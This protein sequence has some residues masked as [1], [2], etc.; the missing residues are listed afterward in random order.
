MSYT[1][2]GI[3]SVA[4]SSVSS[5]VINLDAI[6]T[7]TTTS[8]GNHTVKVW[9]SADGVP[10]T[11]TLSGTFDSVNKKFTLKSGTTLPSSVTAASTAVGILK[12][13]DNNWL[14]VAII[15]FLIYYLMNNRR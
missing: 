15:A 8:D 7:L 3:K 6:P 11:A 1:S 13:E 4:S 9:M 14:M 10:Y 12:V 5:S 2:V